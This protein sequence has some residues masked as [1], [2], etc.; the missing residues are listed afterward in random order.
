MLVAS[1]ALL[2]SKHGFFSRSL[3]RSVL[4]LGEWLLCSIQGRNSV[5]VNEECRDHRNNLEGPV[6]SSF[7]GSEMK[8][9]NGQSNSSMWEL[10]PAAPPNT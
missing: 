3:P 5:V 10:T 8:R 9:F 2:E 6:T 1:I 4:L 7:H